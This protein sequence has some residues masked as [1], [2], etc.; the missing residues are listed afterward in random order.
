M[1]KKPDRRPATAKKATARRPGTR[2]RKKASR[3]TPP[4]TKRE[5]LSPAPGPEEA[6]DEL[7]NRVAQRTAELEKANDTLRRE[8]TECRRVQE[9][10]RRSEERHRLLFENASLA[11]GYY[12]PDGN[13]IALNSIAARNMGGSPEDFSGKPLVDLFD[14]KALQRNLWVRMRPLA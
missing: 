10:L 11:I 6:P 5:T 12:D 4:A 2:S 14:Q 1:P 7:E 13:I 3:P 8:I 9:A